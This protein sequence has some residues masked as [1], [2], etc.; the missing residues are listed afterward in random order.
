[1]NKFHIGKIVKAQGIKGEV[2]IKSE[3][4]V[5]SLANK[6]KTLYI[7]GNPAEVKSFRIQ[8]EFAFVLFYLITDRNAAEA[9][10]G[11]DVFANE[12][13]IKLCDGDYFIKDIV[14]CEVKVDGTALGKITD[15]LQNG[16]SADVFVVESVPRI[17]FPFVEDLVLEFGFEEKVLTLDEKRFA[18]VAV[19]ED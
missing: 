8:N 16:K 1:M 4:S 17:M 3:P 10:V 6:L 15:V 7:D 14:G 19:Y 18:E 13:E 12:A 11:K 5:L 9:L 2:K